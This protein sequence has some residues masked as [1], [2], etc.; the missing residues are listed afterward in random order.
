M[1]LLQLF[2][3]LENGLFR[4]ILL[5]LAAD[6]P[7]TEIT[8]SAAL[9]TISKLLELNIL[10]FLYTC[11]ILLKLISGF[12]YEAE[13]MKIMKKTLNLSFLRNWVKTNALHFS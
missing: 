6:F 3:R 10:R 9:L 8:A 1:L 5:T 2:H 12:C 4:V 7:G 11:Q 13:M